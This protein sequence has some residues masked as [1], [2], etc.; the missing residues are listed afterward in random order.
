VPFPRWSSS[1]YMKRP[2]ITGLSSFST[3]SPTAKMAS[4][5]TR[6]ENPRHNAWIGSAGAAGT[7]LRSE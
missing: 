5:E 7:D 2:I 3:S 1:S 4:S 6:P